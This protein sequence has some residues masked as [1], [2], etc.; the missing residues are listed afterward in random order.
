MP[1]RKRKLTEADK[2]AAVKVRALWADY[3]KKNTGISQEVAA[4][5]ADMTQSAF[6]QFV[7]GRVP[8][9]MS[10]VLKLARLFGVPPTEIRD[11]LIDLPYSRELSP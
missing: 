1:A 11:D 5:R 9:R 4:E 3:K 8:M 6:S 10:P 7:L 2:R